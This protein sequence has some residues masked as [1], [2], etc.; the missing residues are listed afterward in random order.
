MDE[1]KQW[2]LDMVTT[3]GEG[4]MKVVKNDRKELEYDINLVHK[5]AAE[6]DR[7]NS[8]FERVLLW[9]KCY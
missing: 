5:V 6:F 1:Q 4:T 2:F 9:V 8:S 7:I 3:P